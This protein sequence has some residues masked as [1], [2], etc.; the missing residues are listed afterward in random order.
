[1]L[2][3][4]KELTRRSFLRSAR[5]AAC[6]AV[7]GT[8]AS[9]D[10]WSADQKREKAKKKPKKA[11]QMRFGFTTYTWGKPWDIPTL[12][13]NCTQAKAL[14]VELRTSQK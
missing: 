5:A 11:G 8:L 13:A 14:G 1:M 12:I 6:L 10:A 3:D 4:H 9:T 2:S 7:A